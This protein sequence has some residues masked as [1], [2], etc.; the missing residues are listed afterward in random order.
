MRA[1]LGPQEPE[2]SR[3]PMATTWAPCPDPMTTP[4][5]GGNLPNELPI[6]SISRR[7]DDM[8]STPF[9]SHIIHYEPPRG[10]LV[11]KYSTYDGTNDP[12][13]HIMHY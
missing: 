7:L 6:G 5:A 4:M 1:R 3:P 2:R 12:F 9:C 11:P 8:L 13:D 10:F